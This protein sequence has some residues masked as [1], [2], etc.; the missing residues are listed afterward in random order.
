MAGRRKAKKLIILF[1]SDSTLNEDDEY[2]SFL[3]NLEAA[4]MEKAGILV[5]LIIN[6]SGG[7]PERG[8]AIFDAIQRLKLDVETIIQG[9]AASA[10]GI[11]ALAGKK[12]KIT[13]HSSI[14]IHSTK[15]CLNN[16]TFWQ[17]DLALM[18][19][20]LEVINRYTVDIVCETTGLPRD[21]VEKD[22]NKGTRYWAEEA[23]KLG[24]VH[25]II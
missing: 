6:S 23:L 15:I 14:M 16:Q 10:A 4:A 7:N 11:V 22:F 21:E 5:R 3:Q 24:F 19:L 9:E 20:E 2:V 12:R 17:H 1:V 8:F 13:K 18:S 25:E